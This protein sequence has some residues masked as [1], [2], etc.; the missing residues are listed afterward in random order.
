MWGGSNHETAP[1]DGC[2]LTLRWH[3]E[4]LGR[5][6]DEITFDSQLLGTYRTVE[7]PWDYQK[8]T[9]TP[10]KSFFGV[11]LQLLLTKTC[12]NPL[13]KKQVDQKQQLRSY[14]LCSLHPPFFIF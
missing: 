4:R 10:N 3:I 13:I 2:L 8:L 5:R 12:C 6:G 14:F 7:S 1:I 11:S 9:T